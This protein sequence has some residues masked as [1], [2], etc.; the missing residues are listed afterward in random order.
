LMV[1]LN[2]MNT[3][4]NAMIAL[5]VGEDEI[6]RRIKMRGETSGRAD[7]TDENIIRK[8][9]LVYK[10]ETQPVYDYFHNLGLA[11]SINGI[12]DVDDIFAS[13]TERIERSLNRL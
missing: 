4:L 8:R 12:G 5:E 13:L 2:E 9:F 11:T 7:D 1:L 3:S 10:N 6:V